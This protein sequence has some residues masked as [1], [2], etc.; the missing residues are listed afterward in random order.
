[1]LTGTVSISFAPRN[2]HQLEVVG[3]LVQGDQAQVVDR[4][5]FGDRA[6]HAPP[7]I[8]GMAVHVTT[9]DL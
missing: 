9:Q 1:M 2:C 8:N 7:V 5:A 3:P 6:V 4:Q